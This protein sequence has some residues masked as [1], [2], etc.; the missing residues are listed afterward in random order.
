MIPDLMHYFH[1]Y[2]SA[3]AMCAIKRLCYTTVPCLSDLGV[4]VSFTHEV[5]ERDGRSDTLEI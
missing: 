4:I 2:V 5:L 1:V 3:L